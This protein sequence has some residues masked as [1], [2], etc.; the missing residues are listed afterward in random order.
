[1]FAQG[2]HPQ[3]FVDGGRYPIRQPAADETLQPRHVLGPD[4]TS[5]QISLCVS[6]HGLVR[7]EIGPRRR[8]GRPGRVNFA[9]RQGPVASA[10]RI[11]VSGSKIR[12]PS[13][14]EAGSVGARRRSR[15]SIGSAKR[16]TR[17]RRRAGCRH[18]RG[19]WRMFRSLAEAGHR[20][21]GSSGPHHGTRGCPDQPPR[22]SAHPHYRRPRTRRRTLRSSVD[23][24]ASPPPR[25][26]PVPAYA[27][28]SIP[29]PNP[30]RCRRAGTPGGSVARRPQKSPAPST[31]RRIR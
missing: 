7:P 4:R 22:Q 28:G 18:H 21:R 29:V 19:R 23:A 12:N 11:W 10:R 8:C 5:A 15:R 24:G 30:A 27:P 26:G 3:G 2:P 6:R 13:C 16:V 20:T 1:M 9:F 14:P 25:P 17:R 31:G